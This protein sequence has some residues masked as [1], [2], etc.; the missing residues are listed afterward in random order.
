MVPI[1]GV[2][3]LHWQPVSVFVYYALETVVIGIFNV[4]RMLVVNYYGRP[5]GAD[6]TGVK[7]LWLIP[8]FLVHYYFFVAVQLALF[9]APSGGIFG[10]F[11]SIEKVLGQ[12]GSYITLAAF[13]LHNTALFVNNFLRTG[14]YLKRTIGIQM[15]EPYPRIILQQFVV[16]LGSFIYTLTGSG[17]PVLVIFVIIKTYFDMV[18]STLDAETLTT[19]ANKGQKLEIRN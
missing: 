4:F 17:W 3:F 2:I 5:Q 1:A 14:A 7:G 12:G 8:F 13:V 11:D 15:F 9:F 10:V 19:L 18:L 16:I 6:E